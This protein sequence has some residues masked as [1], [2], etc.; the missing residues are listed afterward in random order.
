MNDRPPLPPTLHEVHL[1]CGTLRLRVDEAEF[2]LE[3]LCGFATRRNR[4]RGF[5]IVS[6]VLGKHI[7]VRPARMRAM[8]WRLSEK[9]L[10]NPLPMVVVALAET[11]TGLGHGVFHGVWRDNWSDKRVLFQHTTRY[12]LDRPLVCRFDEPHSHAPG[13][14][15]YEPDDPADRTTLANARSLVLIDDEIST[16]RTLVNLAR[17]CRQRLQRLEQV[18]FVC[19]TNWLSPERRAEIEAEVGLPVAFAS[20][21][22]GQLLFDPAPSF[23]PGPLPDVVGHNGLRDGLVPPGFGRFGLHTPLA[24]D[25]DSQIGGLGLK[26]GERVLVLGTGEFAHAPFLLA[27]RLE[28]LGWDVHFQST[29]RSPV[30]VGEDIHSVIEFVDNYGDGIP[31]Y[32][33]NVADRHYDRIII[34]YE[35]HPLPAEHSLP[36]MLGA[37]PVFF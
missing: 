16:G 27:R 30:L 33:Y 17:S 5:L 36:E 8:H 31:N 28:E 6:K 20:L 22:R 25:L 21:L 13:H 12:P 11:A 9:L 23:D 10:P 32:V 2:P 3:E 7:P 14:L 18:V 15:L 19:L 4:K 37:T 26:G 1:R 24:L 35:T 34:G 29:T